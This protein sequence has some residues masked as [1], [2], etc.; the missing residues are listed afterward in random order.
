VVDRV[1]RQSSV[2]ELAAGDDAAL[3]GCELSDRPLTVRNY[4]VNPALEARPRLLA[5][6]TAHIA[7]NPDL[8]SNAPS[9]AGF[10]APLWAGSLLALFSA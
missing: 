9:S 1:A 3:P 4:A 8:A 5:G 6:L 2:Q 10:P 7:V